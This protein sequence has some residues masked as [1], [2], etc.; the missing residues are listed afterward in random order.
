VFRLSL[1][2]LA[3]IAVVGLWTRGQSSVLEA[4]ARLPELRRLA[5][6]QGLP[7]D[8]LLAAVVA[9]AYRE[10]PRDDR[11]VAVELKVHWQR[12][13]A[14]FAKALASFARDAEEARRLQL[15]WERRKERWARLVRDG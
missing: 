15:L 1:I 12:S 4:E 8:L 11:A 6:A 2:S 9:E 14:G 5:E 13:D 7:V 10:D 3:V